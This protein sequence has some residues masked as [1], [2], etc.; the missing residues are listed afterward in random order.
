MAYKVDENGNYQRTVRCSH[1]YEVGHNKSSCPKRKQDLKDNIARYTKE[2]EEDNFS[3]S[4][5]KE[6]TERYLANSKE[7]L[8]KMTQKGKKRSC[9]FCHEV[10]H[11][12]RTCPKRKVAVQEYARELTSAR[13]K[14]V[15]NLRGQ[16]IFVGALIETERDKAPAIIT[17]IQLGQFGLNNVISATHFYRVSM[18][19]YDLI[20]PQKNSWGQTVS[21]GI[22]ALP[23]DVLNINNVPEQN[24]YRSPASSFKLISAVN[25]PDN[26]FDKATSYKEIEKFAIDCID[27]RN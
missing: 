27:P 19:C 8:A 14:L 18:V 13:H 25:L 16:G 7:Q 10:G 26:A 3:D 22:C 5:Y 2:L 1:C 24:I 9:G 21:S 12:R 6:N 11:T 4:W 15:D 17:D 23:Q 20:V